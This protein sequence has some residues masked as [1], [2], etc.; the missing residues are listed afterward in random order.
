MTSVLKD[1]ALIIITIA[2][3][4][5]WLGVTV[6]IISATFNTFDIF[7]TFTVA[8]AITTIITAI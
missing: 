3:F 1:A 5:I 6:S 8:I 2:I 4:V 7:A